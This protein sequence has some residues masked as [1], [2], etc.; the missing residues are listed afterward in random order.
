M[1][2]SGDQRG[3]FGRSDEP[4]S[5]SQHDGPGEDGAAGEET[6]SFDS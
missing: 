4:S 3:Q 6:A 5:Q 1:V 2:A